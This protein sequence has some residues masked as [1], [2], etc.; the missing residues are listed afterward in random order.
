MGADNIN[1]DSKTHLYKKVLECINTDELYRLK[2]DK[3][4]K[5]LLFNK[6]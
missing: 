6:V 1:D 3:K 4:K 2:T 5:K